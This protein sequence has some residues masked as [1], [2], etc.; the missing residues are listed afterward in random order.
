MSASPLMPAR[1]LGFSGLVGAGRTETMRALFGADPKDSGDIYIKGKKVEIKSPK[2]AIANGIAFVTED[3]K[4]EGLILDASVKKQSFPGYHR[5]GHTHGFLDQKKYD[6]VGK[7]NVE[8]YKIKT[9]SLQTPAEPFP[10][11]ISKSRHCKMGKHRCGY[12]YLR[13]THQGYRR[14]SQNRGLQRDQQTVQ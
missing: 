12:L 11:V 5:Q 6:S 1:L 13:R 14:R 7:E 2:D 8:T 9:P 10:A 4:G 3:R